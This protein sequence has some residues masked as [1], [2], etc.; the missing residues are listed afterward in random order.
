MEEKKD[1]SNTPEPNSQIV[2]DT[3]SYG[4]Q[5]EA[6]NK[7]STPVKKLKKKRQ[8]ADDESGQFFNQ[9]P[10]IQKGKSAKN[11]SAAK[12]LRIFEEITS[13]GKTA[14]TVRETTVH[15]DSSYVESEESGAE[16][17]HP[18]AILEGENKSF[19]EQYT[20]FNEPKPRANLKSIKADT[21]HTLAC[22]SGL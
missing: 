3:Q 14:N 16:T 8:Q 22:I 21:K 17:S 1:T 10:P 19:F 12:R 5:E 4:A 11:N 18:S 2:S 15:T 9:N 6:I 13:P 7:F 20:K